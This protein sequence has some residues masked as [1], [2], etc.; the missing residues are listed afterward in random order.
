MM[1]AFFKWFADLQVSHAINMSV[2][3][4][5]LVQALHLVAVAVFAGAILIVDLRLLGRGITERP[6]AEVARDARPWLIWSFVALVA[7]GVPQLMSLAMK[8]YYSDF[9]WL[10]M[11]ILL[12][13]L[14]FTFTL[15]RKVTGAEEGRVG[16]LQAKLVGLVSIVLWAGVAITAR[17]IGVFS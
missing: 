2:W 15:R 13:A 1:L 17:F 14:I 16:P 12:V 9:F 4:Y 6:V 8:E 7:T 3:I 5:P 10:K 11:G